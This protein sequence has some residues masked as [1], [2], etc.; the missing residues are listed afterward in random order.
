MAYAVSASVDR[1]EAYNQGS[2]AIRLLTIP[3]RAELS[4]APAFAEPPVWQAATDETVPPFSAVCYFAA[5]R[6]QER[7]GM[8]LGL[9]NASWG[10]S[11][12]EAW[13]SEPALADVPGY[14]RKVVQLRQYR[15][16]R[17][18]A[19]LAF[20]GDW[21]AWWS[22]ASDQGPVWE[23]GV[24][25]ETGE[26]RDAPLVNWKTYPDERLANH[27]G[28][29]WFSTRFELS[30]AQ[31]GM[32]ATF[33]L[34]RIDEVDTTWINGRFVQNT[35]G[36][37]TKR[38]YPLEAGVLQSGVNQITVNVLNT[39]DAG[40]MLGPAEEVGIR[41]ANG[42][43]LALGDAWQYRFI[44]REVGEPPRSPWESVSGVSGM[45]NGMIAPLGAL[46]PAGVIWYQGESNDASSA[47]YQDLLTALVADWRR[48]FRNDALPFIVVQLPNYGSVNATPGPSGWATIRQAQQQVALADDRVG[49]VVT[50]DVGDDADIH[51]Q[52]KF[53]VGERVAAVAAAL[54]G[55]GGV[56]DGV[57]PSF[58]MADAE[59]LVLLRFAPPLAI[60]EG[61]VLVAG[62]TLCD[63][64]GTN[65][66]ATVAS[67]TG[68]RVAVEVGA[69][70]EAALVRYCWSDGGECGLT[71]INGL[72]VSSFEIARRANAGN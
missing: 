34:G 4:A 49:L 5:R 15:E 60:A 1:P 13:I 3:Q 31:A 21:V 22:R 9:I 39:W 42:S 30:E 14:D 11:A 2:R 18:A 47:S 6:M 37:G 41:F 12:I 38:E 45:F 48:Y 52:Q 24:L 69:M 54:A 46:Q 67:H 29:V 20:A 56:E 23:Q 17:R 8:P 72:P 64:S 57:V 62:F 43:F 25:D 58:A 66:A 35:F 26:W 33:V 61:P 68:S 59:S 28:I 71:A 40:G 16:N 27:H 10:G 7:N 32:D 51:P 70:P 50:H 53:V 63:R 36:Y 65:C 55:D 19:E 44:P